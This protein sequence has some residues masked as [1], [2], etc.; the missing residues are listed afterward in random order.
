MAELLDFIAYLF[1]LYILVIFAAAIM[2]WLF[3]F[4]VVNP[5]N[6]AVAM[7]GEFLYR[8]TEPVLRPIRARMPN[9]GG[10]DISPLI[11]VLILIFIMNVII[12]VLKRTVA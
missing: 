8:M 11:L 12:P 3:V 10:I 7:V 6:P 2:S 4:N 1:W 5:R 9:L